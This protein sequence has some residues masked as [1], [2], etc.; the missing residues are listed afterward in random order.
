MRPLRQSLGHLLHFCP[1]F[2]C[3]SLACEPSGEQVVMGKHRHKMLLFLFFS[4]SLYSQKSK[5]KAEQ[6]AVLHTVLH[7]VLHS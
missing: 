7:S 6:I 5:H 4:F 2:S 1:G 3:L